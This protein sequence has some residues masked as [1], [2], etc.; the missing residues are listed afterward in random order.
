MS[1]LMSGMS[2]LCGLSGPL[3]IWKKKKFKKKLLTVI[4]TVRKKNGAPKT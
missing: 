3:E 4:V 1:A 2:K